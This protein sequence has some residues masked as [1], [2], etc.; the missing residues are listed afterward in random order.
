MGI[1]LLAAALRLWGITYGLPCTY[2]R[3]DEDRLINTALRLSLEDP[4]P[5]YFIWP[6][7]PFY[8]T[9]GLLEGYSVFVSWISGGGLTSAGMLYGPDPA[10][11][12]LFLRL[13][14]CGLGIATVFSL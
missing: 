8:L 11:Q 1:L 9:R 13:I 12:Y 4:N 7:L 2:C 14:F 3:P 6:S 10:S 5:H